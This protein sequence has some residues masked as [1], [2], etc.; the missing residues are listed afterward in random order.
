MD[1]NAEEF[2]YLKNLQSW[3]KKFFISNTL[4]NI[5]IISSQIEEFNI[6]LYSAISMLQNSY[7]TQI[8]A[9]VEAN[10]FFHDWQLQLLQ[11]S[12]ELQNYINSYTLCALSC[13]DTDTLN[14]LSAS[15]SDFQ[16][17][18][19]IFNK[20]L[21]SQVYDNHITEED[22]S[23]EICNIIEN[24]TFSLVETWDNFK[25]TRWFLAMKIIIIIVTFIAS[26]VIEE[27]KDKTLDYLGINELWEKTGIYELIDS[28][29]SE[30]GNDVTEETSLQNEESIN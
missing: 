17:F 7:S 19:K 26:P 30:N 15:L 2:E 24:K 18:E 23:E 25:K 28:F 4:H 3:Y 10:K 21:L 20:D 9:V 1:L 8:A 11:E 29:D 13:I 6:H 16:N 22:I 27:V 14:R 5:E 12:K